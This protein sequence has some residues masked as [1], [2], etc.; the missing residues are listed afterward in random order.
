MG[1]STGGGDRGETGLLSGGRVSKDDLRIECLGTL[2]EL[3]AFLGDAR[4]SGISE[5]S[6][7]ALETVQRDLFEVCGLLADPGNSR[8]DGSVS[9]AAGRITEDIQKLEAENPVQCFVL[10]GAAPGAAKLDICRT[11]CRR[12]ER[13]IVSLARRDAVPS[14]VLR[15]MNRLSDFLFILAR[16]EEKGSKI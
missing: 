7:T 2:D 12:A 11:V 16:R 15:Y 8:P 4:C 10:P 13:R 6:K 5:Q 14:A 1:I 3:S 9:A